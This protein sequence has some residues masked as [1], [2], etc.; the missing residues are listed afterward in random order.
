M[1][2]KIMVTLGEEF[3][4]AATFGSLDL[5]DILGP[6]LMDALHQGLG[7]DSILCWKRTKSSGL[8]TWYTVETA[9]GENIVEVHSTHEEATAACADHEAMCVVR[10]WEKINVKIGC[11][12][13][14][15]RMTEVVG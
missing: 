15:T 6:A 13:H 14:V 7:E 3:R 1:S 4:G 5:A 2:K 12:I 8:N 9:L 10:K 11:V